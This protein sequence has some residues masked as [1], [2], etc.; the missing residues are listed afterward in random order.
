MTKI[1]RASLYGE[2]G[3]YGAMMK[4]LLARGLV[5]MRVFTGQRGRGGEVTRARVA[6][7]KEPV[8][9]YVDAVILKPK[10]K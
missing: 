9:R 4:E 7:D 10:S 5:E 6:Y 2:H 3:N 8:K 1:P